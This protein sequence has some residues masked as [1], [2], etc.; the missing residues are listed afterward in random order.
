MPDIKRIES[1]KEVF[2]KKKVAAYCRVSRDSERL[3]HS[4]ANQISYYSN[5]IQSNP[6][7]KYA[8]VYADEGVTGTMASKREEFLRM[9]ADCDDGKIDIIL[10]KS[11]SRFARNTLDT[12]NT[13]RHLKELGIEVRFEE[14][15]INTL[16][17]DGELMMT[18]FAS[19][20]QEESRGMSASI[21]WSK[22]KTQA[23]GAMTNGSVPYGYRYTDGRVIIDPEQAEIVKTIFEDY[24]EKRL[25][26]YQIRNKLNDAGISGQRGGK[27]T[28]TTI[29][30]MLHNEFYAGDLLLGKFY[31]KDPLKHEKV[32][33][34]GGR[35]MYYS[36]EDHEAII[37]RELYEKTKARCQEN[38]ELGR[39]VNRNV[40]KKCFSQNIICRECG[41]YMHREMIKRSRK[42]GTKAPIWTCKREGHRKCDVAAPLESELERFAADALGISEFSEA[43]YLEGVD[44]MEFGTDDILHVYLKNGEEKTYHIQRRRLHSG[45]RRKEETDG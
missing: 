33:N 45:R 37:G 32:R 19:F 31:T 42:Y 7:W 9:L 40:T 18:I 22:Q 2:G 13:V 26:P 14:Q 15:N 24:T 3:M 23:K 16:S 43:A 36:E 29:Y 35:A 30:R 6:E 20:A 41:N 11:I 5:L 10:T 25:T 17:G 27:W 21:Q 34:R 1:H 12:L 28:A 8:G 39:Y 44:H 38:S 4:V